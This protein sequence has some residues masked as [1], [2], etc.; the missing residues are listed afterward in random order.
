MPLFVCAA[1]IGLTVAY[2]VCAELALA[3]TGRPVDA[4]LAR[5]AR[6]RAAAAEDAEADAIAERLVAGARAGAA[7]TPGAATSRDGRVSG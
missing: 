2:L 1:S 4:Q 7:A 6:E 3:T 5:L